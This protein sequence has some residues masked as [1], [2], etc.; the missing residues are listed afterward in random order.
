VRLCKL[1]FLLSAGETETVTA[2]SGSSYDDESGG[3]IVPSMIGTGVRWTSTVWSGFDRDDHFYPLASTGTRD[4]LWSDIEDAG[5]TIAAVARIPDRLADAW[6][7]M[8]RSREYINAE[9]MD[10]F[11]L[12]NLYYA[13]AYVNAEET[14]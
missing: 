6:V 3:V 13:H 10:K 2:G 1:S 9:S 12:D 7:T 4:Q 8:K 11:D 14:L 5:G